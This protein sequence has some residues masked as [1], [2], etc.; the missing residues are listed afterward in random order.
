MLDTQ[1]TTAQTCFQGAESGRLS[2]PQILGLL[3]AAGFEGYMVDFRR[4]ESS[5]FLPDGDSVT[6]AGHRPA[7][8]A[9]F[10]SAALK[11]AI[12]EAQ[13]G[14][15]GYSYQGFCRKSGA[16]G[17]AGYIVSLPGRRVLYYG[18]TAETHTEHFPPG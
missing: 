2:F 4:G 3:S 15:P 11:A 16:A 1:Y 6:F 14:A 8:A 7:I 13:T 5:Y 9:G 10:D 18:R 17:C 12:L